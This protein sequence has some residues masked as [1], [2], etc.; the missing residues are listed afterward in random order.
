MRFLITFDDGPSIRTDY[1]PTLA[2]LEQLARNDV[3]NGIK[4]IFFVQTRNRNGGG[5]EAGKDIMRFT[6]AQ[7]H[8]LGLHSAEPAGHVKHV[9]MGNEQL[10]QS[11]SNG[12]DDIRHITGSNPE[13]VRPPGFLFDAET[14]ELYRSLGLKML[15]SDVNARDGVIHVF[16]VS[17]RRRSHIRSELNRVYEAVV[18]RRLPVVHGVV[19]VMVT[20]HDVNTYTAWHFTEYLHI[21]VEQAVN[22]GLPLAAKPFFDQTGEIV[23]AARYR[24]VPPLITAK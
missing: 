23:E 1:N 14:Q 3:Q 18:L 16:N 7:G 2:I 13:F 8:V 19:P 5:T 12:I 10:N 4:G 17:L 20:F 22:V 11:L 9:R 15:L 6:Y 24:A 21:L